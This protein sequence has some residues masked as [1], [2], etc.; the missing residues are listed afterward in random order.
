MRNDQ[1]PLHDEV[2]DLLTTAC[3]DLLVRSRGAAG[4]QKDGKPPKAIGG[5]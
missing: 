2:I 1:R 5:R 3:L 4:A